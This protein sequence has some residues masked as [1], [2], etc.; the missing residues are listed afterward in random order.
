VYD[1]KNKELITHV[2]QLEGYKKPAQDKKQ[3]VLTFDDGPSRHLSRILNILDDEGV[4][5]T[6]FW[7]SR[8]LHKGR[9]WKEVI[10]AGHTIGSHTCSHPLLINLSYDHQYHQLL[11]SKQ[12]I[13]S[14]T[15]Q[16]VRYF[17]PPFGQFNQTTLTISQELGLTPVFWHISSMDWLLRDNPSQMIDNVLDRCE[18]GSIILFHE[19][20][21]TCLVLK[22]IIQQL[23]RKGYSF[24]VL[25]SHSTG[26]L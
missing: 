3:V 5:A 7:Q 1:W 22:T 17:R 2:T 14:I 10:D 19:L 24:T 20:E 12:Q 21:H 6:F 4:Y 26:S 13:E 11:Y 15:G 8:L 18:H 25:P 16:V 23:K 9:P